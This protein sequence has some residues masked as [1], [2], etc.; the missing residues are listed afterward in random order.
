MSASVQRLQDTGAALR[1]ALA[2]QDWTAIGELDTQCRLAVEEAMADAPQDEAA[3]RDRMQEL[4]DLYQ[5]LV[6]TCRA[7]QGRIADELRQLNHAQNGAK[8][9]QLFG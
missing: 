9:Y 5:E 6:T 2:S 1:Q 3:L 7:E 8:V 4:L